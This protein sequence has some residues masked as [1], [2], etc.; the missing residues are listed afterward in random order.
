M[1]FCNFCRLCYLCDRLVFLCSTHAHTVKYF[2][3]KAKKRN[4]EALYQRVK[5]KLK[6]FGEAH[7]SKNHL[8]A[9]R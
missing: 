3:R 7:F 8:N 6:E 2:H 1:M 5:P 4:E 9:L